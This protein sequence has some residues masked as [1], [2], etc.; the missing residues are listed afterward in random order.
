MEQKGS[1]GADSIIAAVRAWLSECGLLGEI[2]SKKRFID[3]TAADN[4]NYKTK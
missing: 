4:K 1:Q 3:W 2:P